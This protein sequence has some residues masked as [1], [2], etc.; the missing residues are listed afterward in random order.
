MKNSRHTHLNKI[1]GLSTPQEG[2]LLRILAGDLYAKVDVHNMLEAGYLTYGQ[3]HDST[4]VLYGVFT[5]SS[6]T[7]IKFENSET[8]LVNSG[9]FVC[10][11]HTLSVL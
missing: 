4:H 11:F 1:S 8:G 7:V 9:N 3:R 10:V 2:F 5:Y 6:A